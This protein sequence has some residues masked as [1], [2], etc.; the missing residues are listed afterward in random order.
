MIE[1]STNLISKTYS[2]SLNEEPVMKELLLL[3][4]SNEFYKSLKMK[5]FVRI[6]IKFNWEYLLMSFSGTGVMLSTYIV[7]IT[8]M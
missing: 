6:L 2:Y 4:L 7:I 8:L 1:T 5:K 3:I